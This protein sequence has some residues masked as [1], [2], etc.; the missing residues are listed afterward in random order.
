MSSFYYLKGK[1]QKGPF[2]IEQLVEEDINIETL[3]WSKKMNNWVKIKDLSDE[4]SF[5]KNKVS[6]PK[7]YEDNPE[8][9]L[10]S[11]KSQENNDLKKD[12]LTHIN[13]YK[14]IKWL[15]IWLSF[16]FLALILATTGIRIFNQWGRSKT[17]EFWPFVQMFETYNLQ[18][19]YNYMTKDYNLE[20]TTSFRGLFFNYDW[21]EFTVYV[22]LG[23]IWFIWQKMAKK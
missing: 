8:I 10:R 16:H 17:N 2:T 13:D 18:T 22:V 14:S 1:D 6:P 5:I 9:E 4:F 12:T 11:N 21:S 7:L 19:D 15:L 3:V 23:L 20:R